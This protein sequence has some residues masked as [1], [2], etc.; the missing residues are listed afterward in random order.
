MKVETDFFLFLC[1]NYELYSASLQKCK[2]S[3][4]FERKR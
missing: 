4:I 3:I 2:L 1:I